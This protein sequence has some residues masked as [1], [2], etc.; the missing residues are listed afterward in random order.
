MMRKALLHQEAV[1]GDVITMKK[2]CGFTLIELLV[3]IAIIGILAAILLPALARARE[4]AR[5]SSCASNL[6]QSGLAL[7]MYSNESRGGRLPPSGMYPGPCVDCSDPAFPVTSCDDDKSDSLMYN[8]DMMY[9]EY[10]S[11]LSVLVCPSDPGWGVTPFENPVTGETDLWRECNQGDRGVE[12]ADNSYWYWGH[13]LDKVDDIPEHTIPASEV[14]GSDFSAD[15][16]VAGQGLAVYRERFEG[17]RSPAKLDRD[18]DLTDYGY[19]CPIGCGNGGVGAT[20][21]YRL[22]EGIERFLITDINNPAASASAQSNLFIMYDKT[23]TDPVQFSHVP[24]GTNTLF[25]D[26]HVEFLKYPGRAPATRAFAIIIGVWIDE[27]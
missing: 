16:R 18:W 13:L 23:A 24:G 2:A 4:A 26:G 21:I 11:D 17:S 5:R 19:M 12:I 10:I 7:K 22:R 20:T 14:L 25:L 9:P 8:L 6:R 3:V 27:I 1:T 15:D